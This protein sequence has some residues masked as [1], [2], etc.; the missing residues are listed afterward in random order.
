MNTILIPTDF[1]ETALNAAHYAIGLANNMPVDRI[2]LYHTHGGLYQVTEIPLEYIDIEIND[3]LSRMQDSLSEKLEK[4][5][6]EFIKISS[7]E[8]FFYDLLEISTKYHVDFIVM[9]ITG[10]NIISQK[11]MG[12]NTVRIAKNANCPVFIIPP[13]ATYKPIENILYTVHFTNK[14]VD[15]APVNLIKKIVHQL[16]SKLHILNVSEG[17][18]NPILL[19]NSIT[20]LHKTF[21]EIHPKYEFEDG[22]I[23]SEIEDYIEDENIDLLTTVAYKHTFFE[24]LFN[25]SITEKLAFHSDIPLLVMQ[26]ISKL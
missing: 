14:F 1:S 16:G 4:K 7:G 11:L 2:I 8:H 24:S 17:E 12:S 3:R 20:I 23:I 22:D 15:E 6:I 13:N 9:G 10:K 19:K 26:P 21:D 5:E 18:V 25:G